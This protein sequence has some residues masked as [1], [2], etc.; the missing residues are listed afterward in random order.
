[1]NNA[2]EFA[3]AL[4]LIALKILTSVD[5]IAEAEFSC[6]AFSNES[7]NLTITKFELDNLVKDIKRNMRYSAEDLNALR[8]ELEF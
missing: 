7:V 3:E 5:K 6:Q 2:K 4:S 1:M 8:K